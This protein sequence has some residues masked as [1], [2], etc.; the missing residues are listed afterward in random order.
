LKKAIPETLFYKV[1]VNKDRSAN[2]KK[3]IGGNNEKTVD[4][5][6]KFSHKKQES[7][8]KTGKPSLIFGPF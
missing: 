1:V 6:E 4:F 2:R 3:D 8:G 7:A 5:S